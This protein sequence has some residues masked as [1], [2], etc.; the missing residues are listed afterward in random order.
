MRDATTTDTR[1][2]ACQECRSPWLDGRKRW[3]LYLTD[4]APPV[5]L[6]YC[7]VCARREFDPD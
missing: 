5:A 1:I 2:L 3:R 6:V 7:P 4:D